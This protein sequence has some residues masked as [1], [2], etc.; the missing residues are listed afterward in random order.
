VVF[1]L[2]PLYGVVYATLGTASPLAAFAVCV[3]VAVCA[4]RLIAELLYALVEAPG[5]RLGARIVRASRM[6]RDSSA[7]AMAA[8][9]R[10]T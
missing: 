6:R 1:R 3:T 8:S 5:I 2:T 10:A 9:A 7:T 4:V